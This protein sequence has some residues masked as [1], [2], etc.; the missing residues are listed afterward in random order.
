MSGF[1]LLLVLLLMPLFSANAG[2]P[3][4]ALSEQAVQ[5]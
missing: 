1:P 3:S 4:E 2:D 5:V